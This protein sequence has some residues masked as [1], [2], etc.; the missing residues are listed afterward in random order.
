LTNGHSGMTNNAS[1]HE[2][3]PNAS[4]LGDTL[5]NEQT[6]EIYIRPCCGIAYDG[7]CTIMTEER[8][9]FLGGT[10]QRYYQLC[11]Q[12]MC[13]S[14]V[15]DIQDLG[16]GLTA[17]SYPPNEPQNPNQGFRLVTALFLHAGAIQFV[18]VIAIQLYVG[19]DIERHV[20]FLRMLLI[21]FISGVGG[22]L[23]GGIFTPYQITC[24]GDPAIYGLLG[25]TVVE[26]FQSW[27]IV[28]RPWR[29][30]LKISAMC[31]LLFFVGTFPFFNNWSHIGGFCFGIVCAIVFVP[32]IYFGRW[33]LA[34][35]RLLLLICMP[36]LVAMLI[37]GFVVFYVAQS[38]TSGWC[39]NCDIIDCVPYVPD[40]C[41]SAGGVYSAGP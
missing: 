3:D 17:K 26:L 27:Q 32:T 1:C 21:W 29:E 5:C 39:S 11:S 23:V 40:I 18:I 28:E 8:C 33:S 6:Q 30:L 37:I 34:R 36:L 35:K 15:C 13:L 41:T 16:D 19:R 31:I 25:V 7:H 38:S 12:V 20:G 22:N 24:G 10:W 9:G 14:G 2:A 4:W